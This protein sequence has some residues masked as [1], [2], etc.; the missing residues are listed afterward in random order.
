[1]VFA[2]ARSLSVIDETLAGGVAGECV[3][4]KTRWPAAVQTYTRW[5]IMASI[6]GCAYRQKCALPGAVESRSGFC[7]D[8]YL[9]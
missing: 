1:M 6:F 8:Y 9:S 7:Y 4:D 2:P 5:R 3:R